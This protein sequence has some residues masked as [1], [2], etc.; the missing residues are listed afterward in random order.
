MTIETATPSSVEALAALFDKLVEVVAERV[1]EQLAEKLA[2]KLTDMVD[3]AVEA[4]MDQHTS[5]YDHDQFITADASDLEDQLAD[6]V[7]E[8]LEGAS[9]KIRL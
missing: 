9:L 6:T 4:A 1:Q 5:D 2:E 7:R 8:V 3:S